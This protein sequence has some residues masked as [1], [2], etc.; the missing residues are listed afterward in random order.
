MFNNFL[1]LSLRLIRR[2]KLY[3]FINVFGLA[4]GIAFCMLIFLF[5]KEEYSFDQFH[6]KADRIY[7]L[8]LTNIHAQAKANKANT[9]L[10][11]PTKGKGSITMTSLPLPLGP[12]LQRE[13]PEVEASVRF[14][15]WSTVV[16][17]DKESFKELIYYTDANFFEVFSFELVQGRKSTVYRS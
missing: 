6:E 3:S 12:A 13:L 16:S 7:R 17:N 9:R 15:K 10:T 1:T 11:N 14:K 4:T 2:N 5:V 8:E